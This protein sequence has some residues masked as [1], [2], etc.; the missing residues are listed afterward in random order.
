MNKSP[1]WR[2]VF[3]TDIAPRLPSAGLAALAEALRRDD[4]TVCQGAIVQPFAQM[5][6]TIDLDAGC[7]AACPIGYALWKAHRLSTVGEVHAAF[8]YA[9]NGIESVRLAAFFH[10]VDG[11]PREQM[12]REL[13]EEIDA[14]LK[15]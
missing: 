14:Y 11:T 5:D 1:S 15:P 9:T 6:L 13:A 2:D 12:R 3:R 4:W 7:T 10:F 8:G